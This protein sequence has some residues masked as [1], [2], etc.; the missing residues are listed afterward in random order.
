MKNFTPD[1]RLEIIKIA[2]DIGKSKA[3]RLYN[4]SRSTIIKWEKKYNISGIEGLVNQSKKDKYHPDRKFNKLMLD[5]IISLKKKNPQITIKKIKEIL[6]LEISVSLIQKKIK[7]YNNLDLLKEIDD[8][9]KSSY[10]ND[11]SKDFLLEINKIKY[12]NQSNSNSL[13]NLATHKITLTHI[14]SGISYIGF[15]CERT[16]IFLSI[17]VDYIFSYLINNGIELKKSNIFVPPFIFRAK[18]S[19]LL[20]NI[21]IKYDFNIYKKS[22]R[23][24]IYA[25]TISC[26]KN[27]YEFIFDNEIFCDTDDLIKK[28]HANNLLKN[29]DIYISK[30]KKATFFDL[31]KTIE[32]NFNIIPIITDSYLSIF[33]KNIN[34]SITDTSY[35]KIDDS[36]ISKEAIDFL[37]KKMLEIDK[38]GKKKKRIIIYLY[39]LIL[40]MYNYLDS[41]EEKIEI[42][43]RIIELE[44]EF[45]KYSKSV[46]EL[47]KLIYFS[48]EK[49]IIKFI[50]EMYRMLGYLAIQVGDFKKALYNFDYY[51]QNSIKN[52]NENKIGIANL[53]LAFL[54]TST[55][56][57]KK[58]LSCLKNAFNIFSKNN[59][60]E[61]LI[62]THIDYSIL[63]MQQKKYIKS[64][65]H[66]TLSFDLIKEIDEKSNLPMIFFNFG[67]LYFKTEKYDKSLKYYNLA[68][69]EFLIRGNFF[70]AAQVINNIGNIFFKK[71]DYNNAIQAYS[72]LLQ[73]SEKL[74][75]DRLK[76][77]A[78][79]NIASVYEKIVDY[80]NAEKMIKR[81]IRYYIRTDNLIELVKCNYFLADL[82]FKQ[83]KYLL[84][85]NIC[86]KTI[87]IAKNLKL[88]DFVKQVSILNAKV[89][90]VL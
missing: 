2:Q 31:K 12:K 63:F 86:K 56:E 59:N 27:E 64:K 72:N 50:P 52:K 53:S 42:R 79:K 36:S 3:S 18:E 82:K 48:E 41:F 20:E 40:E 88:D 67:Q 25:T 44:L 21:A 19:Y 57:N 73:I 9:N 78:N 81:S 55:G 68:K 29:Y 17:F 33:Y 45:I 39:S 16:D 22:S 8:T 69:D 15:T 35:L 10:I 62:T 28:A 37:S 43:L 38:E 54:Y 77:I 61:Q 85:K 7:E 84:S 66:L 34:Q 74:N 46:S 76:A 80:K 26:K 58:R 23:S 71:E 47:N 4:I 6:N 65:K 51:L 1:K 70:Y 5:Q 75:N 49:K 14:C 32:L 60:I 87:I 24:T 13:N 89:S 90:K 30:Q 11:K 83:K